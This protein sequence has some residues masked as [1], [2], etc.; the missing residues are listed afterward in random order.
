LETIFCPKTPPGRWLGALA[1]KTERE[2]Q[3][4]NHPNLAKVTKGLE[5]LKYQFSF[6][7]KLLSALVPRAAQVRKC[8]LG[9]NFLPQDAP[10]TVAWSSC[11]KD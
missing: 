7:S 9:N 11:S 6:V 8:H 4:F 10:G 5:E 2:L 1:Q 3:I